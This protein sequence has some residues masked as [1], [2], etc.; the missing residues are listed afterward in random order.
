MGKQILVL[1]SSNVDFILRVSRF[2]DPGETI[3]GDNVMIAFGGKGANQ[4]I[5]AK[6]LG[7]KVDFITKLGE[8]HY[9][10]TYRWYLTKTGLNGKYM[11]KDRRFP[12]GMAFIELTPTGENRIVVSPGAN[13]FISGRDLK[14]LTQAWRS[15][16]IFLTQ[17]EIPILTV[18]MGLKMARHRGAMTILNPS[19]PIRLRSDTLSLVDLLVPNELEAQFL[20]GMKIKRESD[21]QKM[22]E[23]LLKMG[24][25][26][27]IIT[28]GPNGLLFKNKDS[29]VKMK[30][31]RVKAVDSTGAGDAFMGGLVCGLSEDKSIHEVLRFAS[32]AGALATTKLG[33][34]PSLPFRKE[35]EALLS[36]TRE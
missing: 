10:H 12:T 11:L 2:H 13:G 22:A 17:L 16:Q 26:N 1:G 6:R 20:T 24:A 23:K 32:A 34:Q 4:A 33:A 25:K 15:A 31:F 21:I 19:P 18:R 3:M 30:A 8:D 9:G 14:G 35:L 5:A 36:K 27:V 28:L 7:A 29:E